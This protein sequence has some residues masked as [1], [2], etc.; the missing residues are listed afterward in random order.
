MSANCPVPIPLATYRFQFN[1]QFTLKNATSLVEYLNQLGIS[2][3][4]ASPLFLAKQGSLH[5]YDVVNHSLLNPEIGTEEDLE[6]FVAT[7]KSHQMGLILD[8]VPNHMYITDPANQWW[9]DVLENGAASSYAEYFD[10]EWHPP[11]AI[12]DNKVLLPLLDQQ[13]GDAL[14]NQELKIIYGKGVFLVEF[15]QM[16]LPTDPKSWYSILELL[17]EEVQKTFPETDPCLLELKSIATALAHLPGHTEQDKEKVIERRREKEIIKRRLES[18]IDKQPL[19]LNMLNGQLSILNG[20]KG[21]PKSF[22]D[23]ETFFKAQPY[24]LCFWRVAND[25]INYRRFFDIFNYAG[26]RTEKSDVFNA[27]HSLVFD[28]VKKKFINGLRID[29]I[30]GLLDPEQYL[31]D[32]QKHCE[33]QTNNGSF[34]SGENLQKKPLYIVVEKI[35]TG[36]EK[37]RPEWAIHGTVGY[38]FLN[39]V[40]GIFVYQQNKKSIHDVYYTFTEGEFNSSELIY[41]C[42]KLVL[43]V[44]LSSELYVLA[45]KLDKISAQY[46][47]SRDF[48]TESLRSTLRDIIACFPV[49]RSY[50]RAHLGIIHEEDRNY[51][52]SSIN[53]AKRFNPAINISIF[54]F[55]KSV[56]LLEYPPGLSNAQKEEREDFVMRFQ[57]LTGPVMAKGLEDTAFY[58]A[59]PLASLKEV[60]S[61]PY[62]FGI[63]LEA[64]HKANVNR[65]ESWPH[66]MVA[67]STHDTKRS[68]DVRARINVLSEM[69]EEWAQALQRWSKMNLQHKVHDGNQE[70]IPSANEEY[71]LYQTLI[72]TWPLYPMDPA[73]HLQYINRIQAYME[74]ALKEAKTHTSWINPNKNYDEGVQHFINKVLS[75]DVENHFLSDFQSFCS[76][77]IPF[78]MLNSISQILLKF[79]V[80]GVPDIYQGN[81]IWDFSLV[82]PDNRKSVDFSKRKSLF[83]NIHEKAK[84]PT[85]ELLQKFS[86][87]P[88]DGCIK[89]FITFCCL[90]L[91]KKNPDIFLKGDYIPLTVQGNK[92]AHVIAFARTFEKKAIIVIAC[93]FFTF[94]MKDFEHYNQSN[95]WMDNRLLLPPQLENSQFCNAFTGDT[96]ISVNHNG[97]IVIKLGDC[98]S[99]FPFAILERRFSEVE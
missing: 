15:A 81:E 54:E 96:L 86:H 50:I 12:L 31:Q 99:L 87:T 73:A 91:R 29:H 20:I 8:I 52:I 32:L 56:L 85:E 34:E 3:C 22:D 10:I 5:G 72:G 37:L 13:Y 36:D 53:F 1:K 6:Q 60:G 14:E 64:F 24:R 83:K 38:D 44:S 92:Q 46:R 33:P 70:L 93:R 11:R 82:D 40:N 25:E 19:F 67:T 80:T 76:K 57:Q 84:K 58:Q 45:R 94:F 74:K 35:L 90:Q 98:L 42:K 2:H 43:V 30:D 4:Y 7:L 62:S 89:M 17:A 27:I 16:Q 59:Y 68:E 39:Q 71:L 75:L 69:P 41:R 77:I 26:I 47:N 95:T 55:I 65:F 28:L 51:I 18:L 78:G 63:S 79:T 97:Q 66:A 9:F 61:D 49:Y 23:L 48:T 88:D 21:D